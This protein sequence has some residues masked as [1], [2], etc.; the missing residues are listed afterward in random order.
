MHLGFL[1]IGFSTGILYSERILCKFGD[2]WRTWR[3]MQNG[4]RVEF[5]NRAAEG[6]AARAVVTLVS[7][8]RMLRM[9]VGCQGFLHGGYG[10]ALY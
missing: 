7:A 6:E 2:A 10:H 8:D 5:V 4:I 9:I 1:F 3:K